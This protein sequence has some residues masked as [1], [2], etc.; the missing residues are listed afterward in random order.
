MP[1][2]RT[3][4]DAAPGTKPASPGSGSTET[5]ADEPEAERGR[6]GITAAL[7]A[8]L[9]WGV[10]PVY[11]KLVASVAALEVLAHRIVWAVPFG[12]LIILARRQWPEVRR[13]ASSPRV[14]GFLAL[15]SAL[16]A[17]NWLIYIHAVQQEQ[18]FQ[19]SLGY[20]I[21]P[22]F[23][24]VVGVLLFRERLR[25][26][27]VAAAMLA[28][29][30]VAI[31][32]VSGATVPW[33]ALALA[34]SFTIY[35]V[36]RKQVV[37]GG[38]PGLFIETLFLAPVGLL[39]LLWLVQSGGAAFLA[40]SSALD[41]LLLLAGPFT[42]VP[43]LMFALAAR[44]LHLSTIGM[45]QFMAPSLQ[46]LIGVLYGEELTTAHLVCFTCI[47]IAITLFLGD[48]WRR[49]RQLRASAIGRIS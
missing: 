3:A 48:A 42:V 1:E 40:S 41:G 6:N 11:F 2:R 32:A 14:L 37:V 15:S 9:L 34:F 36:I 25:R 7:T 8:Y 28:A 31:L 22:L 33:I 20:Y 26:L 45:M 38:M 47:W 39:Y 49:S 13:A 24:V 35:G 17:V 30:G 43:L 10:M 19:A 21:N 16:I 29:I 27:Q 18:I 23:N 4:I 5:V 46:F 44:R 12:A